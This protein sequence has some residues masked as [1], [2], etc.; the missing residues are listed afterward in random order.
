MKVTGKGLQ[1]APTQFTV[2]TPPQ[3]AALITEN[4]QADTYIKQFKMYDIG[5]PE[6]AS[7]YCAC[8]SARGETEKITQFI[9]R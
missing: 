7:A 8:L 9:F 4:Q 6:S 3:A 2:S 5:L 1:L